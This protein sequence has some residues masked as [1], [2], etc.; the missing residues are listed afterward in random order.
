MLVCHA[1]FYLLDKFIRSLIMVINGDGFIGVV[2]HQQDC[3]EQTLESVFFSYTGIV[4]LGL[5]VQFFS[6]GKI[7]SFDLDILH[8]QKIDEGRICQY[9]FVQPD[10]VHA[11]IRSFKKDQFVMGIYFSEGD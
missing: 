7:Y 6:L 5:F 1:G 8:F 11:P 9:R 4:C 2:P 10:A 3:W